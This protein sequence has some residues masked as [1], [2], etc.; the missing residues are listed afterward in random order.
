MMGT[1]LFLNLIPIFFLVNINAWSSTYVYSQSYIIVIK[2]KE[3][4][5]EIVNEKID[6]D[7]NLICTSEHEIIIPTSKEKKPRKFKTKMILPKGELFPISYSYESNE[8]ISYDVKVKDAQIIVT[9]QK[10]GESKESKYPF[11]PGM[12]MIDLNVYHTIDY[13]IRKYDV[14]KGGLQVLRTYLLHADRIEPLEV[15]PVKSVKHE[16]ETKVLQL[17]S[18]QIEIPDRLTMYLWVNK[19]NRLYRMFI[20]GLNIDVIQS[21]LFSE[22]IA[23]NPSKGIQKPP[24]ETAK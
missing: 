10:E 14:Q 23:K 7:G 9:L 1:R 13:L 24:A 3:A 8:G 19:D 15:S 11:D 16:Y 21:D 17:K 22:L 12:L 18:Y 6:E 5:R 4:G 20:P 2:G